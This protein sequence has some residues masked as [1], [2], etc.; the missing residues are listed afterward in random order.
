MIRNNTPKAPLV[1]GKMLLGIVLEL[2]SALVCSYYE[3]NFI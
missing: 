3:V 2:D 1:L